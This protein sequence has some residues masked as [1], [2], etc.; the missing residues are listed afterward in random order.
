MNTQ[1]ILDKQWYYK[2]ARTCPIIHRCI[3]EHE[4]SGISWAATLALMVKIL[5]E[6]NEKKDEQI[7]KLLKYTVM[8]I[9]VNKQGEG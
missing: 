7:G 5:S 6:T 1:E 8:P 9:V 3:M 2:R 4:H